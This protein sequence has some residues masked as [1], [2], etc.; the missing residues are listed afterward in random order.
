MYNKSFYSQINKSA[1]FKYIKQGT[2]LTRLRSC[3]FCLF[4][5]VLNSTFCFNFAHSNFKQ[6]YF[7]TVSPPATSHISPF[8]ITGFADGESSFIISVTRSK[9]TKLGWKVSAMFSISL[10]KSDISLLKLIQGYFSGV[11]SIII[12]KTDYVIYTVKGIKDLNN[13]VI[14]HFIKYP[15]IT[16]KHADFLLFKSAVELIIQ[17]EHLTEQGLLKILGIKTYLNNGLTEE[18][19]KSFIDIIPI[20]RPLVKIPPQSIDFNWIA[21]FIEGEG[22]FDINIYKSSAS[23]LGFAVKLRFR[24]TQHIR[25]IELM[26]NL[27]QNLGCGNYSYRTESIGEIV[28]QKFSDINNIIIPKF[29][30]YPLQGSKKLDFEDFCRAAIL[31][32]NKNHLTESGLNEIK[33]IKSKMNRGRH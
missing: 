17:G 19:S 13:I 20:K 3:S 8:Y 12:S 14:P 4:S 26:K 6:R 27:T 1:C 29:K 16:Q 33:L 24:I 2:K 28:V 31:I 15:L 18:I 32:E 9:D 23:K 5:G 21:G 7:N 30:K 25:D 11:G 22:C 10:H